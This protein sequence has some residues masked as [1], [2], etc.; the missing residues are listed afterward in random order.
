MQ[1]RLTQKL[2][3]L[4]QIF[5]AKYAFAGRFKGLTVEQIF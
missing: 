1:I 2:S 3:L 4:K 5:L